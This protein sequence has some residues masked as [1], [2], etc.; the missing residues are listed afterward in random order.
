MKKVGFI[1]VAVFCCGF[2]GCGMMIGTSDY[3]DRYNQAIGRNTVVQSHSLERLSSKDR[4]QLNRKL[5]QLR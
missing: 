3:W 4:A 5:E 2:T 1:F